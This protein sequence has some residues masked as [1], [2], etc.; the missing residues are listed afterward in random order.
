MY[1]RLQQFIKLGRICWVTRFATFVQKSFFFEDVEFIIGTDTANRI[2]APKYYYGCT[3]ERD[4]AIDTIENNGC[5]F[6]VLGRPGYLL[7]ND[8]F[9]N[10][11]MFHIEDYRGLDISSTQIRAKELQKC[12]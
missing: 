10:R 4:R 2:M 7:D 6:M 11:A 12:M 3:E 8:C 9:E 5:S 1:N